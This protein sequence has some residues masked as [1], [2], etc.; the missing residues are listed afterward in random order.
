GP[1]V[2]G[3][4][5]TLLRLGARVLGLALVAYVLAVQVRWSDEVV[6]A[7]GTHLA[8]TVTASDAGW[9]LVTARAEER[10]VAAADVR[11]ERYGGR[12]FPSVS[13]G[14]PTLAARLSRSLGTVG[15]VLVALVAL[16][17]LTAWRWRWL[18]HALGLSLS[19]AD[20]L[21]FTFYGV[22]F[23]LFVPGS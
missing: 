4:R 17:C 3:R 22:F 13:F 18:V 15:L 20:A 10:V 2:T 19:V 12:E 6:L 21:R 1:N 5:S 7:D 8:G 9:R 16:A 14:V 23:N 11:H